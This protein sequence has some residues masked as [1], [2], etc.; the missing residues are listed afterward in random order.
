MQTSKFSV[1]SAW[2]LQKKPCIAQLKTPNHWS[3]KPCWRDKD[4]IAYGTND[5]S[6]WVSSFLPATT[7]RW[8]PLRIMTDR[9]NP[10]RS[11]MI[12][13]IE[14]NAKARIPKKIP[15][16]LFEVALR[17]ERKPYHCR[18]CSCP[19]VT[20]F[21]INHRVR[22]VR[23]KRKTLFRRMHKAGSSAQK[24]KCRIVPWLNLTFL[25][26]STFAQVFSENLLLVA[27]ILFLSTSQKNWSSIKPP[28]FLRRLQFDV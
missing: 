23:G 22:Q 21:R 26:I 4:P 5:I 14:E 24:E 7:P 16:A 9:L 1:E 6:V 15:L 25:F 28:V 27:K 18:N 11:P 2:S 8:F 20:C 17:T 19:V 12:G 10:W 13:T 3:V